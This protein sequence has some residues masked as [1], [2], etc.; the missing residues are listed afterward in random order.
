LA[1]EPAEKEPVVN[2]RQGIETEKTGVEYRKAKKLTEYLAV[3]KAMV[4][5]NKE[6]PVF[7]RQLGLQGTVVIRVSI[8]P[9]GKIKDTQIITTSGHKSLDRSVL[10]AVRRSG[11]FKPPIDY[12]LSD[13]TFDI[14]I[15]FKLDERG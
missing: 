8:S 12:G 9:D 11:P 6:Y 14:P 1:T 13:V 3:I 7:S 5:N 2:M 15:T 10:G 4:E